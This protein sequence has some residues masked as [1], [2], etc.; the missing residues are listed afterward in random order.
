MQTQ[1]VGVREYQMMGCMMRV[2]CPVQS[3]GHGPC[4]SDALGNA[5]HVVA[6]H[7]RV[8]PRHTSNYVMMTG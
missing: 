1:P 3:N 5:R 2:R 7:L 8:G 4:K 6:A